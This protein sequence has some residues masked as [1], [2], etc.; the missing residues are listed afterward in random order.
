MRRRPGLFLVL[1]L[2]VF[3]LTAPAATS[4]FFTTSDGV[5]L[6]YLEA[7]EGRTLVFVPGW[8]MPAEIWAPQIEHFAPHHHV[9][10]FDPRAQGRSQVPASGYTPERRARDIHEL[11][12]TIGGQP[13]VLIGWS[14]G[15][16]DSLAYVR[17]FGQARL[18]ALVLVDNSIGEEPPPAGDPTFLDRLRRNR[19]ATVER[20][21]RNMYRTP[22]PEDY[23][24]R[25]TRSAL[26]V[27]LGPSIALLS[28]PKPREFWRESVYGVDTP[29]LYAVSARFKEQ[30][31]N[32]GRK[33]P[34]A[35][36]EVFERAG[37]ALFV[38]E[39]ARFNALL[40]DFLA[41]AVWR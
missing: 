15:V 4:R 29:L 31:G 24:K 14:L 3:P 5:Q 30:A 26:R 7:G 19:A 37:H 16:L 39:S 36:V 12:E 28:Y 17:E 25:I 11:L 13:V 8:S 35:R 41:K 23:L 9:I 10:A 18:A 1:L 34:R 20:F 38:D 27:P 33:H 40:D 2:L 32:L 22:Q 21:V 6:H